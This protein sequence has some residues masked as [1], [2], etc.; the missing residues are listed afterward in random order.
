MGQ[1]ITA[2]LIAAVCLVFLVMFG[3]LWL[4]RF[5]TVKRGSLSP[6]SKQPMLLGSDIAFSAVRA[7]QDFMRSKKQKSVNPAFAMHEAAICRTTGR[8]FP[9]AI[10]FL[11]VAQIDHRFLEKRHPGRWVS[12][13]S[14][15]EEEKA[16]VASNHPSLEGFQL[17][18]SSL[19]RQPKEIEPIYSLAKPG[20][21]Y[22]DLAT[23]TL[24]GWQCVPDTSLEVL[25]VQLPEFDP[26]T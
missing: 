17:S 16:A 26:Y 2:L 1:A 9:D 5:V 7:V 4:G 23:K 6:Y 21:L 24:L 14:L 13:G 19:K 22:V 25:I 10:N 3:L 12:W 11:G 15:T 20:P 18:L 8:I